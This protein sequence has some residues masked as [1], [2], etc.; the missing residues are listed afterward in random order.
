M[1]K[2]TSR[3]LVCGLRSSVCWGILIVIAILQFKALWICN[4]RNIYFDRRIRVVKNIFRTLISCGGLRGIIIY[5]PAFYQ[6]LIIRSV[7]IISFLLKVHFLGW[8]WFTEKIL[9]T[10]LCFLYVCCY[11][12]NQKNWLENNFYSPQLCLAYSVSTYKLLTNNNIF[13]S[14]DANRT[15]TDTRNSFCDSNWFDKVRGG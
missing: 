4:L 14:M 2:L 13:I 5:C 7:A 8:R 10:R 15:Y 11:N 3:R 6:R 12:F 9:L 1:N